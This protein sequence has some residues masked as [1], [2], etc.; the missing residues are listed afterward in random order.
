VKSAA[1]PR[2]V[3]RRAPAD[4]SG[5]YGRDEKKAK[6]A[7]VA[8]LTGTTKPV[9]RGK[10]AKEAKEQRRQVIAVSDDVLA[11]L[12]NTS[13]PKAK[14]L[15]VVSTGEAAPKRGTTECGKCGSSRKFT[16]PAT[17]CGCGAILVKA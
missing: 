16:T 10:A 17:L 11:R 5:Q 13:V 14:K 1:S 3:K 12:K 7:P 6:P 9:L 2:A 8:A 15:L 4:L